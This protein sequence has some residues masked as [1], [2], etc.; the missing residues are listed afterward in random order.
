MTKTK[1]L[2]EYNNIL[3]SMPFKDKLKQQLAMIKINQKARQTK[4]FQDLGFLIERQMLKCAKQYPNF[5]HDYSLR[6][7]DVNDPLEM[8]FQTKMLLSK[9]FIINHVADLSLKEIM[10][11][12]NQCLINAVN[13]V[14]KLEMDLMSKYK[15]LTLKLFSDFTVLVEQREIVDGKFNSIYGRVYEEVSVDRLLAEQIATDWNRGEV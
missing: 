11:Q 3:Y 15:F 5:R 14:C 6:V 4:K 7:I 1:G 2:K 13:A 10:E 12:G 8:M 9:E